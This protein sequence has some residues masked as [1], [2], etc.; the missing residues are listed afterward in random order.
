MKYYLAYGSNLN[1]S[2]MKR[3]CPTAEI[4]GTSEIKGY[5]L[6]FKGSC[7]GSYLTIEQQPKK[8]V[9][10]AVW[11]VQ[12]ADEAN[13]DRYEGYPE[14]YYKKKFRLKVNGRVLDCFAYIMHED[15][16][17]GIPTRRYV[18]TCLEGYKDFGFDEKILFRA[19]K[20]SWC[21]AYEKR[22]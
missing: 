15:R 9:P 20:E 12:G 16:P 22:D 5:Q 1:V 11:G 2:Q 19:V 7:T 10:V 14:F 6:L 21:K 4:I 8:T 17:M 3:R 18:E 13:L